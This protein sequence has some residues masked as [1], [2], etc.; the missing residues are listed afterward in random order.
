[1]N[2]IWG[3]KESV[4]SFDQARSLQALLTGADRGSLGPP[5]QPPGP[6]RLRARCRCAAA[7]AGGSVRAWMEPPPRR[8]RTRPIKTRLFGLRTA[9]IKRALSR[10]I[11]RPTGLL[12]G[13]AKHRCCSTSAC[14]EMRLKPSQRRRKKGK[15]KRKKEHMCAIHLFRAMQ[16]ANHP[17]HHSVPREKLLRNNLCYSRE[18]GLCFSATW[19]KHWNVFS[20]MKFSMHKSIRRSE[21][22]DPCRF[23][24]TQDKHSPYFLALT[25][26]NKLK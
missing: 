12:K 25:L 22:S 20:L 6:I 4:R 26:I 16:S 14:S 18:P 23:R 7:P 17:L 13:S 3:R 1:M 11:V 5:G 2:C 21:T 19:R 15:R 9:F 8:A 10:G 24:P